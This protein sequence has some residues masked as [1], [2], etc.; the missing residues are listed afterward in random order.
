MGHVWPGYRTAPPLTKTLEALPAFIMQ[1]L[2]LFLY[3][4]SYY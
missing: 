1:P 2:F 4:L 3:G